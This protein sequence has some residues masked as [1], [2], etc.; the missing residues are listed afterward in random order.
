MTSKIT[1]SYNGNEIHPTPLINYSKQPINFG[2]IYGY[3]TDIT[4]EGL[5]SGI[6]GSTYSSGGVVGG[7]GKA[8]YDISGI[9]NSQFKTL[10]VSSDT[11]TDLY[12]WDNVTVDSFSLEP[13]TYFLGSFL[14]YTIKLKSYDFPSGIIDPSNEYAFTQNDD[15]TVNVT[16]K[17]SAKAVRNSAGALNNAINFVKLFTGK[18]PTKCSPGFVPT[19]SGVLF[20]ISENINRLDGVY[21][22][23]E[24]YKYSTG[25]AVPY[26]HITSLNINESIESELRKI[27]YSLKIQGSPVFKNSQDIISQYLSYDLLADIQGEF[28]INTSKW[29]KDTYSATVD[30]GSA[31]IDIKVGYVSGLGIQNTGFFDYQVHFDRDLLTNQDNWKIDGEFRCYGPL[32]FKLNQ[33]QAFKV[34]TKTLDGDWRYYLTGL[35]TGSSLYDFRDTGKPLS[36]NCK[37]IVDENPKLATLKLS[38]EM[39]SSFEP[40]GLSDLKYSIDSTPSR[41]IYELMP[42]A[43]IE[44]A[45]V[46]Q[47][48]QMKTQPKQRFSI[49]AKTPNASYA[50]NVISGYMWR[51]ND[52]AGLINGLLSNYVNSGNEYSDNITAFLL[53]E[54]LNTGLYDV[55]YSTEFLGDDYD[56]SSTLLTL[57]ATGTYAESVPVRPKGFYF[58][59]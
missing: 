22:V 55:A 42:S 32:D 45:F 17:I 3:N 10:S 44:G 25:E 31:A 11:T 19:G 37:I 5:Y 12:R 38:C 4:L 40:T 54:D 39:Q 49:A 53:S 30:S 48:L 50:F 34:A 1:I 43:N 13:S 36:P 24:V 52:A 56:I 18:D 7:T 28:G 14:K 41:W 21:S 59:Y 20:S 2:Y 58:G 8:I 57:V 33:I 51:K 6:T 46:L 35:I 29:V 23:S 26:F 27:D 47:D 15:G 16:H 9:F